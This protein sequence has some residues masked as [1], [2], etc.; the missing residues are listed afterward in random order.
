MSYVTVLAAILLLYVVG[1]ATRQTTTL[2]TAA[3]IAA[4]LLPDPVLTVNVALLHVV[5][6]AVGKALKG[7][8]L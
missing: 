7:I 4:V 3:L 6:F 1:A 2:F 5:Y 8:S